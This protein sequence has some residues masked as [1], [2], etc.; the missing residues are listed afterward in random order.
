MKRILCFLMSVTM[1]IGVSCEGEDGPIGPA[2]PA[3]PQ[4]P[5]GAAGLPGQPGEDGE[6]GTGTGSAAKIY[7]YGGFEFNAANDFTQGIGFE[8]N[9]IVVSESDLI[10]VYNL[11]NAVEDEVTGE[12]TLVWE[13]LP[14]T[15]F[16]PLGIFH[17]KFIH[18]SEV[19]FMFMEANF[20]LDGAELE[21]Y[22]TQDLVFRIVVV[23]GEVMTGGRSLPPV[24]YNNYNEVVD[25]YNIDEKDVVTL[26]I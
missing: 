9:D 11:Y 15:V 12:V 24:D 26:K 23:P 25:Y 21:T 4:G 20:D 8:D 10:L 5:Q 1:I 2:G 7:Q 6:D 22:Y 18:T 14:L 17:Y 16:H 19:V 13:P 3:G